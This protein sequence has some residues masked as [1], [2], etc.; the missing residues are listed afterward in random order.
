MNKNLTS[1]TDIASSVIGIII[2]LLLIFGISV[3]FSIPVWL[4]WNWLMPV[5][6]GVT[7]VNL[8]QAWGLTFLCSLLF[9][10]SAISS[11]KKS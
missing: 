5:I 4:L 10:S 1:S 11:D 8:W 6:F 2:G 7:K 9:K 3:L